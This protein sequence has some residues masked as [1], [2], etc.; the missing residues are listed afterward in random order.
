[1]GFSAWLEALDRRVVYV[2]VVLVLMIPLMMEIRFPTRPT[3]PAQIFYDTIEN[4]D[5]DKLIILC[6]DW[7]AAILAE[8]QPQTDAALE[9][10][11][12]LGRKFVLIGFVDPQGPM[13]TRAKIEQLART[14]YPDYED[15]GRK[16]AYFGFRTA[17][18]ALPFTQ[19]IISD[20]PGTFVADTRGTPCSELPVM[21]GMR[22]MTDHQ[23]VS[24]CVEICGSRM[25]IN[26]IDYIY[27]QT[28]TP[29]SIGVTGVMA[30]TMFPFLDSGQCAGLLAGAKGAAE[31][32]TL[33]GISE[34]G[35]KIM[36]SQNFAHALIFLLIA[37]GNVGYFMGRKPKEAK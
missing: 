3:E 31:Y 1:M 16:W 32:E 36:D 24:V 37:I 6:A 4:T 34:M 7:D 27:G 23:D 15:Y 29:V 8:C 28:K 18:A 25:Y 11:M 10:I 26:W 9:H 13:L 33:L 5:P 19:S 30:P 14:K 22:D 21:Q 35:V 17:A 20:L 12:R 2:L